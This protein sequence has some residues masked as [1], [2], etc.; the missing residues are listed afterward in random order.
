MKKIGEVILNIDKETKTT[1]RYTIDDP[2]AAISTIYIRKTALKGFKP[3][4]E[5]VKITIE[6]V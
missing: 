2:T 3:V 5:K 4:P 6:A 1:Q